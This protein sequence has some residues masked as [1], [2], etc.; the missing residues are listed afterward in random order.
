MERDCL[1]HT[2]DDRFHVGEVNASAP[3]IVP[4]ITE[5]ENR[6]GEVRP[7]SSIFR[8]RTDSSCSLIQEIGNFYEPGIFST[9]A[10]L[11]NREFINRLY[12]Y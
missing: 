4:R 1:Q 3:I 9:L 2:S 6:K 11:K 8:L 12:L 7:D 5:R 10:H